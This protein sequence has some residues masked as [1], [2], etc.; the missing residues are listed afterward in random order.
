MTRAFVILLILA[1]G[2]PAGAQEKPA[3]AGAPQPPTLR[4]ILITVDDGGSGPELGSVARGLIGA[5][6][7][8]GEGY[9]VT[10][11]ED[12][13]AWKV[14]VTLGGGGPWRLR[15]RAVP[16]TE[17]GDRV[18][19]KDAFGSRGELAGAI[20]RAV[21]E[22][23]RAWTR[24]AG[25]PPALA[26]YLSASDEAIDRYLEGLAALRA[27]RFSEAEALLSG[28]LD[29]DPG[30]DL[31]SAE[32]IAL[33]STARAG[34]AVDLPQEG[35]SGAPPGR[36]I[37]AAP[38][39][40]MGHLLEGIS[41]SREGRFEEAVEPLGR[42]AASRPDDPRVLY[43]RGCALM[44]AGDMEG[45]ASALAR[46]RERWPGLLRAYALEAESRVRLRDMEEAR[47][48]LKAMAGIVA[49]KGIMPEDSALHPGLMLGSMELLAGRFSDALQKYEEEARK[50]QGVGHHGETLHMLRTSIAEM[51]RDLVRDGASMTR[52]RRIEI[53][54]EALREY[55]EAVPE[56]VR[57]A[58]PW[59]AL[60]L[61]GLNHLKEGNTIEAW[62][63]IEEIKAFAGMPGYDD[64]CEAY[65][66]A[67]TMLKEGDVK[68]SAEQF[69]RAAA[70][71]SHLADIMDVVMTQKQVKNLDEAVRRLEEFE[72][73]LSRYDPSDPE[74]DD[75]IL[76]DA[77][78]AALVPMYH[79]TWARLAFE[80]GKPDLSRR[81]FSYMLG[82]LQEPDENL[83]PL[84]KEAYGRGATPQ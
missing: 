65:L 84:V 43:W 64:Y 76:T 83:M 1:L 67:A 62:R 9:Q 26:P 54:W 46:A 27:A 40:V 39:P 13:A 79:Y 19:F 72:R 52:E 57:A 21:A 42:A 78:L 53:A 73:R 30:F 8:L 56:D 14:E 3:T 12:R 6:L 10:D 63:L 60:R 34:A 36:I 55:K 5:A 33:R 66:T 82:Y 81:H 35:E 77:H 18:T 49:E 51:Q 28:A 7:E 37:E 48:V 29:A 45:A 69:K 16:M 44:A 22:L 71:R 15:V 68:G 75:L 25:A 41:L 20:D 23:H 2:G 80:T 47:A 59:E 11:G 32:L 58:R 74:Y 38:R 50:M 70:A 17:T 31:A 61:E 4:H 24:Q